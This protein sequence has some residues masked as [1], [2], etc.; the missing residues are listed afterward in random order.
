MMDRRSDV[1][2]RVEHGSLLT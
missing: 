1:R 2:I